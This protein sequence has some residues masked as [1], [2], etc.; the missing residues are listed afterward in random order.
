[1]RA[2]LAGTT[3]YLASRG[4]DTPRLDAELLLAHALGCT[5]VDLY[6]D[7]DRPVA[8]DRLDVFRDFVRRRGRRE[9]AAYILGEWGFRRL[10]LRVDARA[11]IPRPETEMVVERCLWLLGGRDRPLVLDVGVGSGAIA[12]ALADEHPGAFV[13]AI[14]NSLPAL[15]LAEENLTRTGLRDRVRLLEHDLAGGLPAGPFDLV[16]ANPPYVA[17]EDL[18]GLQPEVRDWEPHEALLDTGATERIARA[19]LDALAPGGWLVLETATDKAD[20]VAR[21]LRDLGYGRVAV[22]EDLAGRERIVEGRTR[23]SA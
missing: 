22:G 7:H 12:L 2:V 19:G 10:T 1:M 13:T 16:A 18:P 14:D 23:E 5:R 9:P 8:A 11:L 6:L 15:A 3:E 17:P 21:L 4:I 20:A